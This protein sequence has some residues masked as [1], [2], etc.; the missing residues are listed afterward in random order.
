MYKRQ[1]FDGSRAAVHAQLKR[2][3][4]LCI[5]G[6]DQRVTC[7]ICARGQPDGCR[8]VFEQMRL[9]HY[10]D[11]SVFGALKVLDLARQSTFCI[12]PTSDTLVRSHTYAAMLSGCVPLL[13]DTELPFH[14][15]RRPYVTEWAWRVGPP[16]V[17]LNYSRFAIVDEAMPLVRGQ[18]DSLL[19]ALV[20]LA[21]HPAERARLRALQSALACE[22]APRMRYTAPGDG[23]EVAGCPPCLLYTSPSPRD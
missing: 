12:E 4:A 18:R 7:T 8:R 6:R 14:P 19:P 16:R 10:H 20:R 21:T 9:Q 17:T 11:P 23:L 5:D 2:M 22:A 15:T 3:G 13:L 1:S